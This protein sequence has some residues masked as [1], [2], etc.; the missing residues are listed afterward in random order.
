MFCC[1]QTSKNICKNNNDL[2]KK[3]K[4]Y[5]INTDEVTGKKKRIGFD[6][7]SIIKANTI[8]KATD[9][10]NQDEKIKIKICNKKLS[11]LT[12]IENLQIDIDKLI[13]NII[14]NMNKLKDNNLKS[15]IRRENNSSK[16]SESQTENKINIK[17]ISNDNI[18]LK[19]LLSHKIKLRNDNILLLKKIINYEE[20][21]YNRIKNY[22]NITNSINMKKNDNIN[23]ILEEC[24]SKIND[25]VNNDYNNKNEESIID[26]I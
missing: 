13:N 21:E 10:N 15:N 1:C 20:N 26:N 6:L 11:Y 17:N 2:C 8:K 22:L 25:V 9:L 7:N 18:Y 24:D 19:H 12:I 3:D 4:P 14:I 5:N 16:L 23:Y